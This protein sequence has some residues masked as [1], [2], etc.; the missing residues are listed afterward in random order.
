VSIRKLQLEHEF[1]GQCEP[2]L[3]AEFDYGKDGL[4]G[5]KLV[6]LGFISHRFEGEQLRVEA[7]AVNL[8]LGRLERRDFVEDS[9]CRSMPPTVGVEL[10]RKTFIS[11]AGSQDIVMHIGER[12]IRLER[13]HVQA[14]HALAL[15]LDL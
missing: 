14:L 6:K 15:E 4:R 1:G 10:D 8:D 12:M 13:K 3:V 9:L 7:D 5:A 11:I 2:L